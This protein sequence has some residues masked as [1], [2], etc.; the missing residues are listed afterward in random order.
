MAPGR[1]PFVADIR[2]PRSLAGKRLSAALPVLKRRAAR[3]GARD[4]LLYGS[5]LQRAGRPVS[6]RRAF[7]R[8]LALAPRS[9]AAK[10]AAAVGDFTKDDPSVAFSRLGPLARAHPRAQVVRY[11]LG[12]ML[13]WLREV[14]AARRELG[15]AEAV[16]PQTFYGR[17]AARLL[18]R[19]QGI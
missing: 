2:V 16:S 3:G 1:P 19:L 18:R 9:I 4:W 13:L 8:A 15:L 11:H 12:V 5:F 6:A 10:T 17:E 14:G 7:G